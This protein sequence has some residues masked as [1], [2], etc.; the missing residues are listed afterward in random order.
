MKV[1]II[2]FLVCKDIDLLQPTTVFSLVLGYANPPGQVNC[3]VR[4]SSSNN[5]MFT[6]SW[7]PPVLTGQGALRY[8]VKYEYYQE[9]SFLPTTGT[10]PEFFEKNTAN[11]EIFDPHGIVRIFVRL[12]RSENGP[13]AVCLINAALRCKPQIYFL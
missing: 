6:I 5:A 9:N 4:E 8:Q 7:S 10:V 3:S 1:G 13:E 11:F 2:N 12:Y